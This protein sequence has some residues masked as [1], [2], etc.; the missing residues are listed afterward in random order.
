MAT[1]IMTITTLASGRLTFRRENGLSYNALGPFRLPVEIMLLSL[2]MMLC[3]SLVGSR[4]KALWMISQRWFKLHN[5]GPSPHRRS[6]HAMASDGTRVFVL[7]GC[8]KGARADEI[9]L[10]HVFDTKHIKYPDPDPNAVNPNEGTTQLARKSSTGP[11]TQEQPRQP[12]SSSS[13]AHGASHLPNATPAVSGR[14]ASL[15]I[16]HER[17]PGPNGQPS[18]LTGVNS[19]ARHV[20]EDDSRTEE[21]ST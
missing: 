17:N 3:M 2:S 4:A 20:P 13:E 12:K 6:S 1:T 7:G 10:I 15:Q 19:K 21:C 18:E 8:S 9:F 5:V 11:T 16:S 14:P